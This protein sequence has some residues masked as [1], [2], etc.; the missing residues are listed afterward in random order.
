MYRDLGYH[1]GERLVAGVIN[2][3]ELSPAFSGPLGTA[4]LAELRRAA[5]FTSER[6][7]R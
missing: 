3:G 1:I 5:L 4:A 7:S 6:P 2:L